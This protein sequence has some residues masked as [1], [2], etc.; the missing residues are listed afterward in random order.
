MAEVDEYPHP[1][2]L[3]YELAAPVAQPGI[4][5]LVAAGVATSRDSW[6]CESTSWGH[7][8]CLGIEPTLVRIGHGMCDTRNDRPRTSGYTSGS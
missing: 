6:R 4:A 3:G 1:I 5:A 7:L 2:H 8:R